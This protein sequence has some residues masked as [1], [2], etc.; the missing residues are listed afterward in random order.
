M[1]EQRRHLCIDGCGNTVSKKQTRCINCHTKLRTQQSLERIR[2]ANASASQAK[3]YPC[4][5]NCGHMLGKANLY[6]YQCKRARQF[7]IASDSNHKVMVSRAMKSLQNGTSHG[8]MMIGEEV[9]ALGYRCP[10]PEC[11]RPMLINSRCYLHS[12]GRPITLSVTPQ[13]L[14]RSAI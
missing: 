7:K 8:V 9:W 2:S 13:I 10:Y 4:A 12:T 1:S 6:C 14:L 11:G 3:L 5:N